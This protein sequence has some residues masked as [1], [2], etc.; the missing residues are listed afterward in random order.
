MEGI[1]RIGSSASATA[2]NRLF[3]HQTGDGFIIVS[4]FGAGRVTMP[5]AISIVL[6]RF[7]ATGGGMAKVVPL[8]DNLGEDDRDNPGEV[9]RGDRDK[10]GRG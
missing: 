7:V 5:L 10:P 3:A 1:Y 9:V 8:H 2:H 6:M 4:G